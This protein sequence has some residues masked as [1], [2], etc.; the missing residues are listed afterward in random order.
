MIDRRRRTNGVRDQNKQWARRLKVTTLSGIMWNREAHWGLNKLKYWEGHSKGQQAGNLNPGMFFSHPQFITEA[1]ERRPLV[2]GLLKC[3]SVGQTPAQIVL[4]NKSKRRYWTL[5]GLSECVCF[6]LSF[7]GATW[8]N[9]GFFKPAGTIF[10]GLWKQIVITH[11]HLS[12]L[13]H[14]QQLWSN[15]ELVLCPPNES[16]LTHFWL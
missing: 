10:W 4:M 1:W 11:W 3:L 6:S 13:I 14:I 2:N 8:W 16:L 12:F 5:C 9:N 15:L 7:I